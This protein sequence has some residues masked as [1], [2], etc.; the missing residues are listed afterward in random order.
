[1]KRI[2]LSLVLLT[3]L[4]L[5]GCNKEKPAENTDND[6]TSGATTSENNDNELLCHTWQLDLA[7]SYSQIKEY[8][9]KKSSDFVDATSG[10]TTP[11]GGEDPTDGLVTYMNTVYSSSSIAFG[12]DG[13]CTRSWSALNSTNTTTETL[14]YTCYGNTVTMDG[15]KSYVVLLNDH[16]LVMENQRIFMAKGKDVYSEFLHLEYTR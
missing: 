15:I 1:M 16:S 14:P 13:T 12:T 5:V 4:S 11:S 6:G 8:D 7:K 3:S 9:D 2:L 10:A